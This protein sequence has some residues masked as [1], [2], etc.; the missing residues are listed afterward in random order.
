MIYETKIV[1]GI[2][3]NGIYG[4]KKII[5]IKEKWRDFDEIAEMYGLT[6]Q[7]TSTRI[8]R[9][10]PLNLTRDEVAAWT[11][12]MKAGNGVETPLN[13]CYELCSKFLLSPSHLD[14]WDHFHK[15]GKDD[16]KICIKCGKEKPLKEYLDHS[17]TKVSRNVCRPCDNT[18]E[19]KRRA[20]CNYYD[21]PANCV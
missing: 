11:Q 14:T 9:G 2:S 6:R 12:E 1:P 7:A 10:Q 19:R 17:I 5:L 18:R 16:W 8:L 4:R 15:Q 20:D 3:K 13:A 21:D